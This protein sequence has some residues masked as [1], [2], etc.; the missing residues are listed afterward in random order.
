M[1]PVPYAGLFLW[2]FLA[3]TILPLASEAPLAAIVHSHQR[4]GLPVAVATAGNF[5]GAAT[6]WWI[7]RAAARALRRRGPSSPRQQ[8]AMVLLRR[9]GPPALLFSWVP[10]IGDAIVASAGAAGIG[11][12]AFAAWTIPGKLARYAL[13]A[14]AV[15]S[16]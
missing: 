4:I 8:Q 12:A 2:S 16:I 14:A 9:F 13:V 15:M 3:A 7:G 1:V 10:L 5:L 11:F 6:T